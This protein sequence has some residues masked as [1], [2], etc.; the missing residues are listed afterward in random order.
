[1][2]D[3]NN[4][5]DNILNKFSQC[6]NPNCLTCKHHACTT[7]SFKSSI[8]GS[9]HQVL[10]VMTCKT[11]NIIYLITCSKCNI[12]YVGETGKCLEERLTDHRSIITKKKETPIFIH[13]NKPGHST[14]S[15]VKAIAIEKISDSDDPL[16]KRNIQESIWQ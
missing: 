15:D 3:N 6:N 9:S 4:N 11:N 8:L 5:R 16:R 10:G 2:D 12:Q 14:R 1:M 7:S 13:F